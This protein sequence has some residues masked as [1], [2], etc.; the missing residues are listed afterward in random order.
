MYKVCKALQ[1][2]FDAKALVFF[3]ERE[4][5]LYATKVIPINPAMFS[6]SYK[7]LKKEN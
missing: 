2:C 6:C 3:E 7:R 5:G 1:N 4:T